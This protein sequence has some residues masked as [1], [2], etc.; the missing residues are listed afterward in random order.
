MKKICSTVLFIILSFMVGCTSDAINEIEIKMNLDIYEGVTEGNTLSFEYAQ[1]IHVKNTYK[2]V[3]IETLTTGFGEFPYESYF[4]EESEFTN[5][6]TGI[7]MYLDQVSE[8]NLEES[9]DYMLGSKAKLIIVLSDGTSEVT[10]FFYQN[11]SNKIGGSMIQY[12]DDESIDFI[13]YFYDKDII[14]Y[15]SIN[16][17]I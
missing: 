10:I 14:D 1:T 5:Y 7:E 3:S 8:T 12:V 15:A 13:H 9:I 17:I 4:V 16:K 6:V 11:E 2:I